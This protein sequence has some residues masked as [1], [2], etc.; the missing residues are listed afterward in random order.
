MPIALEQYVEVRHVNVS[1][2]YWAMAGAA[3][4]SDGGTDMI[5]ASQS[6]GSFDAA[7]RI[8]STPGVC[9]GRYRIDGTR[10]SIDVL[11]EAKANG[12]SDDQLLVDYPFLSAED[13]AAAWVFIDNN[14]PQSA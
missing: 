3:G 14:P 4:S 5:H 2:L 8:V 10:I 7:D 12:V 11:A 13:L 9:G 6:A 1:D